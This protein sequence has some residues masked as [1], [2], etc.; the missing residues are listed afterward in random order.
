MSDSPWRHPRPLFALVAVA[1]CEWFA[2]YAVR[3]GLPVELVD[4]LGSFEATGGVMAVFG[5]AST[6][7]ALLAG[8]AVDL[9]GARRMAITGAAL[10]A[11][12]PVALLLPGTATLYAGLGLVAAGKG[13]VQIGI[14]AL[15]AELYAES[16]QRRDAG[17]TLFWL[18]VNGGAAIGPLGGGM[19]AMHLGFDGSLTA[20][21]AIAAIGALALVRARRPPVP[22]AS[23][24]PWVGRALGTVAALLLV[25]VAYGMT[26]HMASLFAALS[27]S[28]DGQ[29]TALDPESRILVFAIVF[30]ATTFLLPPALAWLWLRLG[31]RGP[32][33][34]AKILLGTL[35]ASVVVLLLF[36]LP[37]GDRMGG[38][39][40]WSSALA[41]VPDLLIMPIALSLV[42]LVAP[43]RL[44]GT[45]LGLWYGLSLAAGVVV[46]PVQGA[47][48]ELDAGTLAFL[49]PGITIAAGAAGYAILALLGLARK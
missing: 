39:S 25:T 42:T 34:P 21:A 5:L 7:A 14:L 22:P 19:V 1:A 46:A 8:I 40:L 12:G 24:A 11:V 3:G 33:S 30:G 16:D 23:P 17:F 41:A 15:V 48:Q 43:P 2:Y 44:R 35:L 18:G 49:L 31:P 37:L 47:L 13:L 27:G 38:D 26:A 20:A 32:S 6:V 4:T 45:A 9:A 29:H 28:H 10:L 36:T